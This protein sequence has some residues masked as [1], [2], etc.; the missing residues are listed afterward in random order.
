VAAATQSLMD[1]LPAALLPLVQ[2][3]IAHSKTGSTLDAQFDD[4]AV[5]C[6]SQQVV[7]ILRRIFSAAATNAASCG[8]RAIQREDVTYAIMS[9][10]I[11]DFLVVQGFIPE[12]DRAPEVVESMLLNLFNIDVKTME[13]A[14]PSQAIAP[15]T[16]PSQPRADNAPA[17]SVTHTHERSDA[18]E[19]TGEAHT[20]IPASTA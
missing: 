3:S 11:C 5:L 18:S 6:L 7:A 9:D 15:A 10:E 8:R 16:R 1:K 4:D 20:H 13:E 12:G 14:K 17:R 19:N 2:L